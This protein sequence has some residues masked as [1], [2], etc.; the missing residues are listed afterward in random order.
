MLGIPYNL[1]GR[2]FAQIRGE[3]EKETGNPKVS[4]PTIKVGNEWVTDSFAIAEWVGTSVDAAA[5]AL[6]AHNV[7]RCRPF[8]TAS[9]RP[10]TVRLNV[11]SLQAT[12]QARSLRASLTSGS[13]LSCSTISLR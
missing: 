1:V 8:L 13:T 10:N 5:C 2:T 4:V 7:Q 3:F 11:L 9:L 6:S 12:K